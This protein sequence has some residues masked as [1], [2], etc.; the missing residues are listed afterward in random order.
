LQQGRLYVSENSIFNTSYTG[1]QALPEGPNPFVQPTPPTSS[2]SL[3]WLWI[4]L[5]ILLLIL[6]LT[7]CACYKQRQKKAALHSN[8]DYVNNVAEGSNLLDNGINSTKISDNRGSST[9]I[10]EN[11]TP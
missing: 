11:E 6:I 4:S 2:S 5:P 3:L 10:N 8:Y 9:S 7:S 1:S